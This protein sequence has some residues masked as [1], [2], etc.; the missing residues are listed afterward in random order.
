MAKSALTEWALTQQDS[1]SGIKESDEKGESIL[2][3]YNSRMGVKY[4]PTDA[5]SAITISNAVMTNIGAEDK[6]SARALGF[7]PTKS[8]SGY[9]RDAFR[10]N[11]NPDYRYNRY[12]AQKPDE[13]NYNIGDILVKGRSDTKNW[14]YE[15]FAKAGAGYKSHGDIIVNE[16]KDSKGKYGRV[17]GEVVVDDININVSM[18]EN[19]LA[20]AYHGQSKNDIEAVHLVNRNK[21]I[22]L[23]VFIPNEK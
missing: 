20:V 14:K 9:V 10:T 18:I 17:L 5:W 13:S 6:S 15:D 8:H 1:W 16:G 4:N 12:I 19:Y 11:A 21:L 22:E 2:R 7:N 3:D 23:G